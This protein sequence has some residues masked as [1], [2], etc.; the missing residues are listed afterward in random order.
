MAEG[1]KHT[2]ELTDGEL[3]LLGGAL[4]LVGVATGA[5]AGDPSRMLLKIVRI[6]ITLPDNGQS[7]AHRLAD[8]L[9][10]AGINV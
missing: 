5:S 7:L 1:E 3:T 6:M 2:L 10:G 4:A 8:M 9:E